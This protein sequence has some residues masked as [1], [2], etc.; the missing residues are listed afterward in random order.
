MEAERISMLQLT[1]CVN[2]LVRLLFCA[3]IFF[4]F[5]ANNTTLEN[6]NL[7]VREFFFVSCELIAD[8]S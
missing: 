8:N 2:L 1:E 3:L 6:V 4:G 7:L 5:F